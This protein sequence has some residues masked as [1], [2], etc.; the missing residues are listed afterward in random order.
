MAVYETKNCIKKFQLKKH[1]LRELKSEI[2][3]LK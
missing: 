1:L 3:K 2:T